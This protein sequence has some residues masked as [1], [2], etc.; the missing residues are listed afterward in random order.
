MRRTNTPSAS[1]TS[2]VCR[3]SM[4]RTGNAVPRHLHTGAVG[5]VPAGY[6]TSLGDYWPRVVRTARPPPAPRELHPTLLQ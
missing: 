5:H 3:R 6:S 1:A 2:V 4:F